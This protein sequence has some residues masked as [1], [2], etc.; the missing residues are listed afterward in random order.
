MR[1]IHATLI[2]VFVAGVIIFALQNGRSVTIA[3]L[4][5]SATLPLALLVVLAY[6]TGIFTGGFVLTLVRKWIQGAS[7]R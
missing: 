3:F 2:G 1:Y 6:V 5:I 4:T 7:H